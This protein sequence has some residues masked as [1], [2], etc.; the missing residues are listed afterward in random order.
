MRSSEVASDNVVVAPQSKAQQAKVAKKKKVTAAKADERD[1]CG[2]GRA[3]DRQKTE[4]DD[5]IKWIR[6]DG[7]G[8]DP[9]KRHA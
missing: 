2:T 8:A 1:P 5:Q 7:P 3:G 4:T 6:W 9:E